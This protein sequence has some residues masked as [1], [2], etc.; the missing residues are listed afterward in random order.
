MQLSCCAKGEERHEGSDLDVRNCDDGANQHRSRPWRRMPERLAAG[1][2]LSHAAQHRHRS[3][4][5]TATLRLFVAA[6]GLALCG[7]AAAQGVF[8]GYPCTVDCSG[9]E[10]GY[11]WAEEHGVASLKAVRLGP[12]NKKTGTPAMN[13]GEDDYE[14]DSDW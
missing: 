6:A 11:E 3:L 9:H 14:S 7:S 10:A 1:Y 5:L 13:W 4:S 2:V 12:K 8:H